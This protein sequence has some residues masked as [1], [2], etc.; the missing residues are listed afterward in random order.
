[1]NA[2]FSVSGRA[3]AQPIRRPPGKSMEAGWR[4][5]SLAVELQTRRS[6]PARYQSGKTSAMILRRYQHLHL[7]SSMP[8]SV[9][10][11]RPLSSSTIGWAR[12]VCA[13]GGRPSLGLWCGQECS[14]AQ[15]Q[16]LEMFLA[17][18]LNT[19]A[20]LNER[21]RLGLWRPLRARTGTPGHAN[22]ALRTM[23]AAL[24]ALSQ[25]ANADHQQQPASLPQVPGL[26]P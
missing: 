22:S 12:L 23:I 14:R 19:S 21:R 5:S 13:V 2:T 15:R 20:P 24:N 8:A 25:K 26:L 7:Q 17:T 18:S 3:A 16:A 1:V 4:P 11:G 9:S 6:T 10:A